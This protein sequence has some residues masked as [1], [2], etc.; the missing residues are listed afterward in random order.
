LSIAKR[1]AS[2]ATSG[3]KIGGTGCA[4]F[5]SRVLTQRNCGVLIAARCTEVTRTLLPSCI[6][7]VRSESVK[8][9]IACLAAQ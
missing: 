9:W 7:S 1:I 3:W 5:G 6:S 8:P 2:A 4:S